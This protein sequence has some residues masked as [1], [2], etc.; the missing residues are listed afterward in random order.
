MLNKTMALNAKT[1]K[2]NDSRC[3]NE[4]KKRLCTPKLKKK[5]ESKRP[6]R[7]C[8]MALNARIEGSGDGLNER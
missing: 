4:Y 1:K 8:L 5:N 6:E 7:V 2:R 3:M